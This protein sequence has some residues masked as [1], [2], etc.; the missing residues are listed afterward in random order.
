MHAFYL[1]V[2]QY[3]WSTAVRFMGCAQHGSTAA[4]PKILTH[5][6]TYLATS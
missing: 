4:T 2:L 5:Q 6:L 3:S 1:E